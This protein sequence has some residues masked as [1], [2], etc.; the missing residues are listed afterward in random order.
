[1]ASWSARRRYTPA[2]S[3]SPREDRSRATSVYTRHCAVDLFAAV[4]GYAAATGASLRGSMTMFASIVTVTHISSTL[5]SQ[6]TSPASV[7]PRLAAIS[8]ATSP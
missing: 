2:A 4:L 5:L 6:S 8:G 7:R 3:R 1:M